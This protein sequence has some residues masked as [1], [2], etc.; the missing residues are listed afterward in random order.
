MTDELSTRIVDF[1]EACLHI[2]HEPTPD[3]NGYLVGSVTSRA[4]QMW[5]DVELNFGLYGMQEG[6]SGANDL[7]GCATAE[8]AYLPV[9]SRWCFR[10]ALPEHAGGGN[11]LRCHLIRACV[12]QEGVKKPLVDYFLVELVSA[13]T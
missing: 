2:E 8:I 7:I 6:G 10:I 3:E 9:G 1:Q 5:K 12:Y 11:T 13:D 4:R